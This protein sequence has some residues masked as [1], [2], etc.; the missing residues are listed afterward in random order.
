MHVLG[1]GKSTITVE[2]G[3]MD[4]NEYVWVQQGSKEKADDQ[5]SQVSTRYSQS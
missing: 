2:M 4:S 5:F 3:S 1:R